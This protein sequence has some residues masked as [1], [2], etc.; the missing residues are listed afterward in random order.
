MNPPRW[1]FFIDV[2]GTFTDVVARRPDG[3]VI[4]H[5]LLSSGC[6]RGV[7][8]RYVTGSTVSEGGRIVDPRRTSDPPRFWAGYGLRLLEPGG[9]E[10][11]TS[12]VSE[13]GH[14]RAE[15]TL[16]SR[17]GPVSPGA[18]YELFSDEEAPVVAIRYLMGL[19]LTEAIGPVEVRLG[20]TRATNA[21]L[22][23][24]GA[25]VAFVTTSGFA[26]VLKIGYQDRP[27]LFALNIRK[28]DELASEA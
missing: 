23:R 12:R 25:R 28:R 9:Q 17:V 21:L 18:T 5:K 19:G 11:R 14:D 13:F 3:T 6:V 7:V 22:E 10:V 15:L 20:T 1:Q 4:T 24:K 8:E 2:G 16:E 27:L 26:D